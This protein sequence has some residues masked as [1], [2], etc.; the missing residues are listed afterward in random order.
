MTTGVFDDLLVSRKNAA[1]FSSAPRP[2]AGSPW[3]A[4]R[5]RIVFVKLARQ[6]SER[7]KRHPSNAT[8]VPCAA[9]PPCVRPDAGAPLAVA[10][11]L[12]SAL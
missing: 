3:M 10:L 6:T 2:K 7:P 4:K 8:L 1:I 9:S 11:P 5:S 12:E